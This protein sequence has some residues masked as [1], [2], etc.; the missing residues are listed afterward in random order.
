M[1]APPRSH[2][3]PPPARARRVPSPAFAAVF[4]LVSFLVFACARED[5]R[6]A[7][8]A[9]LR[10]AVSIPP[11]AW[12][13]EQLAGDRVE[14]LTLIPPGQSAETF[15][16]SDRD[17]SR[18]MRAAAYLRA[19]VPAERGNWLDA[20]RS[21][22][23]VRVVDVTRRVPRRAI[24]GG[25]DDDHAPHADDHEH[26]HDHDHEGADPHVWLSP[27]N[28]T[29]MAVDTAEALVAAAPELEATVRANL[30]RLRA[31]FEA[32]DAR[33]RETLEPCRGRTVL[34]FHPAWGY[35]ADAYGLRQAAIETAGRAP[36]DEAISRLAAMARERGLRAIV[37]SPRDPRRAVDPLAEAIGAEVLTLDPL[38]PDLIASLTRAGEMFSRACG[39]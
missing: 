34:V 29:I 20:L 4:L 6:S 33:L 25:S 12:L 24:E 31:E 26:E 21:A 8:D 39:G 16:P 23:R 11:Q 1:P 35:F 22:D 15:Q 14:V 36:G 10:I 19:G 28:A 3:S 13:V 17:V 2:A 38:A 37:V 18:L 30:A 27:G 7:D 32:L 5:A 9:R